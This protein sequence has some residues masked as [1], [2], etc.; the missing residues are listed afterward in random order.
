MSFSPSRHP[1]P[2]TNLQ[3]LFKVWWQAAILFIY[4][5][6]NRANIQY[7]YKLL[8]EY[9]S[10]Y[11]HCFRSVKSLL[12]GAEPRFELGP[13]LQQ[14]DALLSE[15]GRTLWAMPHPMWATPH[16]DLS[17]AA[18]WSEPRR[19]LRNH[20]APSNIYVQQLLLLLFWSDLSPPEMIEVTQLTFCPVWAI[21]NSGSSIIIFMLSTDVFFYFN[22]LLTAY[23]CGPHH[24]YLLSKC[25]GRDLGSK[26]TSFTPEKFHEVR[27]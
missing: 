24:L 16:P 13:A 14:A 7:L 12:W 21:R 9:H 10:C 27:H 11:P 17:H 8:I 22:I 5:Y 25:M 6:I 1:S 18:P 20:A 4:F 26:F 23:H 19:T 15:P 2:L 3:H